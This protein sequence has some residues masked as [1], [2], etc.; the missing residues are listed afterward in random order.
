MSISDPQS[1]QKKSVKIKRALISV[2]DKNGLIELAQALHSNGI[3]IISTGGS[4]KTIKNAGIPVTAADEVT[5]FPEILEGRVKTLHPKIHGGILGR[6]GY[7]SDSIQMKENNISA[8][9]L[10]V[11]NLYPFEKVIKEEGITEEKAYENVDI[12]GPAM[13]RAAAKNVDYVTVL[14]SPKQYVEFITLLENN[15]GEVPFDFRRKASAIAFQMTAAYDTAVC[16]YLLNANSG[17]NDLPEVLSIHL[18]KTE[19]LRYGENPHQMAGVYGNQNGYIQCLHGKQL[20]YNNYLDLDAAITIMA[21]F[22]NDDPTVA[23]IKH[24]LPSG[25]ASASNL[26]T[27]WKLAFATDTMSPFGGIVAVNRPLDLETAKEIDSIFTEIIIAPSFNDDALNL[28]TQKAN[29]RLVVYNKLPDSTTEWRFRSIFGGLLSQ[30]PD[31]FSANSSAFKCVTKKEPDNS[32]FND[33][34]FAWMV[35]KRVNSNAIVFAKNK[36]T[37]G[38]GSGQ[39]SRI[40]SS[41]IAVSKAKK[42]GLSLAN[43][44][45]ASDAFF[46]FAD[47]VE[48]AAKAG[49]TAVIQPGGSVRDEEVIAMADKYN[50][51]MIFT[52]QRHF[53]H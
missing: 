26:I 27:A 17:K 21:D 13:V 8:I 25:I 42:F 35:V 5:G 32:E 39:P 14:S 38:I 7:E 10:V 30:Q 16:E 53:K 51:S 47:G 41:E 46:P 9:E 33:M 20:S 1:F 43:S 24:T 40:D 52:G 29:R 15:N 18:P 12:G 23:I 11:C 34:L 49:A 6:P 48:A 45:I 2:F 44:V 50:M 22:K 28:L 36:R 31:S 4:F 19:I 3:E 37:L